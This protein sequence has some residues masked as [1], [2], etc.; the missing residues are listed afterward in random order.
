M[1]KI[2]KPITHI[3]ATLFLAVA[4]LSTAMLYQPA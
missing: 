3:A 2:F 4:S 1:K